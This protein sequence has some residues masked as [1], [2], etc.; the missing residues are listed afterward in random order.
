[1]SW[2]W[3]RRT[4]GGPPSVRVAWVVCGVVA[5]AGVMLIVMA[6]RH[7]VPAPPQPVPH[8]VTLVP[9]YP[10]PDGWTTRGPAGAPTP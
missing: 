8:S 9:Q 10:N 4:F 1:V 7:P 2:P 5:V 6:L 3:V